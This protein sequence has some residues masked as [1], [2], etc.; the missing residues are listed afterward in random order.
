MGQQIIDG[1]IDPVK[2]SLGIGALFRITFGMLLKTDF[3]LRGQD[4]ALESQS[5]FPK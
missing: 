3:L 5:L 1:I 4:N 2:M